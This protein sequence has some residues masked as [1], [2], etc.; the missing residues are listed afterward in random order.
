MASLGVKWTQ[1][2]VAILGAP[3]GK[4]YEVMTSDGGVYTFGSAP[5]FGSL[6]GSGR[7]AVGIA[8]AFK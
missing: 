8:P 1:P 3:D 7:Q 2:A 4:G 6:A 5:F